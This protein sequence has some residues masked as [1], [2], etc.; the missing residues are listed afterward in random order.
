VDFGIAQAAE[1]TL[2]G[3]G[4]MFAVTEHVEVLRRSGAAPT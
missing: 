3:L 2:T 4:G 1:E